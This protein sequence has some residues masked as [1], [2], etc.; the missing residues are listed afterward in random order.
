VRS[1]HVTE[2]L[3]LSFESFHLHLGLPS[4]LSDLPTKI[5]CY[6]LISPCVNAC[7][8]RHVLIDLFTLI[9]FREEYKLC[10]FLRLPVT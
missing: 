3:Y 6:F 4:Y 5:L 8:T 7:P 10:E 9:K 2:Q 1:R